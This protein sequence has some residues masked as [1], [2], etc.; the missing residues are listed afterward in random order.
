MGTVEAD[1][2]PAILEPAVPGE[3]ELGGMT[4]MIRWNA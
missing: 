4:A 2:D 1:R 3:A